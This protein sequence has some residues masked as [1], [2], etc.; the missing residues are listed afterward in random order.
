MIFV[1]KYSDNKYLFAIGAY[2]NQQMVKYEFDYY[3]CCV[4]VGDL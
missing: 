2:L 3:Y 1:K 4:I